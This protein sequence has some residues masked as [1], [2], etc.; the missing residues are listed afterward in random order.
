MHDIPSVW[1][2]LST[3]DLMGGDGFNE[4]LFS[5]IQECLIIGLVTLLAQKAL[6]GLTLVITELYSSEAVPT[7]YKCEN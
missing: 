6:Q 7:F 1:V 3:S 4:M 2:L 5:I